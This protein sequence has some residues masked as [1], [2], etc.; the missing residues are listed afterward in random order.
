MGTFS[1]HFATLGPIS[2]I[3]N[4]RDRALGKMVNQYCWIMSTYTVPR[5]WDK[6][7]GTEGI[8]YPGVGPMDAD[9]DVEYHAYYQWVPIV[10]ILQA[11]TFY[12]PYHVWKHVGGNLIDKLT[13]DLKLQNLLDTKKGKAQVEKLSEYFFTHVG[14]HRMWYFGF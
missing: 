4:M 7:S 2:C 6:L 14:Y 8:A 3:G 5:H 13:S 1:E 10:L 11:M 12:L 9:D